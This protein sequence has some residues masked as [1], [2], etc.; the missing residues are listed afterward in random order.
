MPRNVTESECVCMW[1]L[2]H[3]G[4]PQREIG[5]MFGVNNTYWMSCKV[6]LETGQDEEE[7]EKELHMRKMTFFLESMCL[8]EGYH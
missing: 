4:L 7:V 2:A 8:G 1:V 6:V 3:N 5:R